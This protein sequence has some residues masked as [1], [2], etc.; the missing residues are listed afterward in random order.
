MANDELNSMRAALAQ[1][2]DN[3]PL[4]KIFARLCL[5]QWALGEGKE[6]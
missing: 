1:S 6:T 5:E 4:L 2:P 3:V